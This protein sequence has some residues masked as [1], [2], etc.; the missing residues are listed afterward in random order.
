M[1]TLQVFILGAFT[2]VLVYSL[3]EEI[4]IFIQET[5]NS[6]NQQEVKTSCRLLQLITGID[7]KRRQKKNTCHILT[8]I[9]WKGREKWW[10]VEELNPRLSD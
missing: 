9:F 10:T 3:I 1:E 7:W 8:G 2:M 5:R 4:D 6:R